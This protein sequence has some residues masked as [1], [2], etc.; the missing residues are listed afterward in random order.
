MGTSD[1][2]TATM[3]GTSM[4]CPHVS[5]AAALVLDAYPGMTASA[6]LQELLD[7]AEWNVISGL[8]SSDTNALLSVA[9]AFPPTAAPTPTAWPTLSPPPPTI[10]PIEQVQ[11][12]QFK[13]FWFCTVL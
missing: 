11:S 12:A 3:S 1:T 6:V 2:A 10:T 4:A 9:S 8:T 7:A 5:G 13:H